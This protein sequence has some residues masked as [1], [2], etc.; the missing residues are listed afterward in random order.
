[1]ELP[2]SRYTFF[3]GAVTPK[4][5]PEVHSATE[6]VK[7]PQIEAV[8]AVDLVIL[9]KAVAIAETSNCTQGYG[10]IYNNCHGI[11]RGS[12]VKCKYGKGKMCIF[13]TKEE[14]FLA[15]Q[16]IWAE[17]YGGKYPTMR[18]AEVWTG[19]DNAHTWLKHV[20]ITYNELSNT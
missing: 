16:K 11:K 7:A 5:A 18:S 9:S 1:M 19:G 4:T 14:S 12:I 15:F 13:S 20:N 6:Q 8:Q 2:T 3:S 10:V 17:G